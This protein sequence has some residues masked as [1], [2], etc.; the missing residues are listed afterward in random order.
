VKN[1]TP[2]ARRSMRR[3]A[4]WLRRMIESLRRR[5]GSLSFYAE[6]NSPD[7]TEAEVL[8]GDL[9]CILND[10]LGPA[11]DALERAAR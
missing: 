1:P 3:S 4:W 7:A 5:E 9:G 8:A 11:A 6:R 2:A 10:H